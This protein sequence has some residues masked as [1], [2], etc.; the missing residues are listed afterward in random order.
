[1]ETSRS[2]ERALPDQLRRE[3]LVDLES[4][5]ARHRRGAFALL[6]IALLASG[7]WLGWLWL[8]PLDVACLAFAS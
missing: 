1:V 6:A 2:T 7:P 4:R 5:L 8:A 3:R